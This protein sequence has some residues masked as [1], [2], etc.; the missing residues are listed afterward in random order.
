MKLSPEN[1]SQIVID[2]NQPIRGSALSVWRY[3]RSVALTTNPPT[4]RFQVS[5]REIK[6]GTGLGS[7]NTIDDA[8]AAL[9]AY[10]FLSRYP[11]PGSNDGHQYELLIL[12]ENPKPLISTRTIT[13]ILRQVVDTLEKESRPMTL[14]Q[15]LKWSKL[16]CQARRLLNEL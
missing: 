15:I 10:G 3:L 13:M 11:E 8:L 2:M 14:Q 9:E 16:T 4:Q 1:Y 6:A 5:R 12:D 7:M